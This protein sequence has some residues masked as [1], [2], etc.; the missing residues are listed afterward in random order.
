VGFTFGGSLR[1]SRALVVH[2]YVVV[3]LSGDVVVDVTGHSSETKPNSSFGHDNEICSG[4]S[5]V[6]RTGTA[7]QRSH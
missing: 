4:G 1:S 7:G 2:G 3:Q 6:I 5:P